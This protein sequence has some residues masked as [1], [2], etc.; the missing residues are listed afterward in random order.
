MPSEHATGI[1]LSQ[2]ASGRP[3]RPGEVEV[4]SVFDDADSSFL[5]SMGTQVD[6]AQDSG[7]FAPVAPLVIS[8]PS[9]STAPAFHRLKLWRT[10]I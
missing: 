6:V 7:M 10:M 4:R 3:K 2:S 1:E 8:A 9:N 5:P